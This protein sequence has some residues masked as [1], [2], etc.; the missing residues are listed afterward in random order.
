MEKAPEMN[1]DES[2]R[3]GW[4]REEGSTVSVSEHVLYCHWIDTPLSQLLV[5]TAVTLVSSQ[6]S[7]KLRPAA[8]WT[9]LNMDSFYN[10]IEAGKPSMHTRSF[11][12][13]IFPT[14]RLLD[15]IIA[16]RVEAAS[17]PQM[18]EM[19]SVGYYGTRSGNIQLIQQK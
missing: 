4:W 1:I 3:V 15:S 19:D 12:P 14:A 9:A 18:Y 17:S 11:V 2:K 7:I 5:K 13:L 6:K 16:E 8:T 10:K